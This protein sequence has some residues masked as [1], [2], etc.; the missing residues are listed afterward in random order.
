MA[1][2]HAVITAE[3]G[4]ELQ[5]LHAEYIVATNRAAEALRAND[6]GASLKR[7]QRLGT[8]SDASEKSPERPG[9]PGT[10]SG[11]KSRAADDA[12]PGIFCCFA[13][14]ERAR[15]PYQ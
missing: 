6:G 1:D 5:R 14:A 10:H 8:L 4:A 11:R 9:N 2:P 15:R 13:L 3:Q 12:T 7:K